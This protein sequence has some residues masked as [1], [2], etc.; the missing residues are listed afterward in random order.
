MN[1]D[2]VIDKEE[3][4]SMQPLEPDYDHLLVG[5]DDDVAEHQ[6]NNGSGGSNDVES[7]PNYD[8][9]G[10][11]CNKEELAAATPSCHYHVD[12]SMNKNKT[13]D[14]AVETKATDE[15]HCDAGE[16]EEDDNLGEEY[17]LGTMLVRVLQ[18]RDVKVDCPFSRLFS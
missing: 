1:N 16:G 9:L 4:L 14:P 12:E 15:C 10:L 2:E 3:G 6:S 7:L 11:N 18:A 8:H 17:I 13:D 5:D